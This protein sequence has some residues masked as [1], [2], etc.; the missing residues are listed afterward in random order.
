MG[1]GRVLVVDDSASVRSLLTARLRGNGF[2]VDEAVDGEAGAE[3]AISSPPDLVVTDLIMKGISGVQLCRVLRSD[4]ATA[5]VPVVLL[6]GSG[7][8]RSRFWARSA[9]AAAYLSKDRLDDLV[10]VLSK[11][12]AEAPSPPSGPTETG[13][14]P[15][16]TLNER[17]SAVLDAALFDSVIA[18]EVRALATCGTLAKLFEKLA[19]L[20]ADLL[21]YHWLAV[22]PERAYAPLLVHANP[23]D[24]ATSELEARSM[25]GVSPERAA[26]VVLGEHAVAG[27]GLPAEILDITFAG[28]AIGK[29]AVA[30]TARGLSREEVRILTMVAAEV[31]GPLQMSALY[32][33][34]QRLATTDALTGML[35]RRA[36][37]ELMERERYRS[38]RHGF[39]LSLMLL[40][41]DHFKAVNDTRGHAA[42]DAVLKGV[43][44]V[45]RAVARKTD[46]VA[47]W[48]GEEFVFALPQTGEGGAR[49][50]GER[51]RRA[52]AESTHPLP[53]GENL[54]VTV[55]VGISSG[56]APWDQN[57]LITAADAA[58]YAA[59]ARGRNR[60]EAQPP[61]ELSGSARRVKS[62]AA[63]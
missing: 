52:V 54:T 3:Q 41:I 6:T 11:L 19:V 30:P 15:R 29:L 39:P 2:D 42:G 8:K 5:H 46:F 34:A 14:R 10:A 50:A 47:R 36:M 62:A 38:D 63:K 9:G 26:D 40:D 56:E 35:N 55:S 59:K 31:G 7:D 20:V 27:S 24:K 44:G 25:L 45:L 17:M 32:E 23:R 61:S 37:L 53:D 1:I 49:I 48:G 28:E 16:R 51:V 21:N 57:A 18:G 12:L 58:M 60:V 13:A 33:D 43:A 4:P 22:L